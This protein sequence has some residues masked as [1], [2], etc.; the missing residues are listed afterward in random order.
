M[1]TNLPMLQDNFSDMAQP[2]V[3]I[4]FEFNV[5]K[6]ILATVSHQFKDSFERTAPDI[7][8]MLNRLARGQVNVSK[9]KKLNTINGFK[10]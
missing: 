5:M 9:M 4:P 1:Q 7:S 3:A 6:A 10:P 8:A 2:D